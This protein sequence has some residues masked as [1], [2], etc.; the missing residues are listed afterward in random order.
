[1]MTCCTSILTWCNRPSPSPSSMHQPV[2]VSI[3]R[4]ALTEAM[5]L[6]STLARRT[7]SYHCKVPLKLPMRLLDP[8]LAVGFFCKDAH[9]FEDL[10]FR[11]QT[12]DAGSEYPLVSIGHKDPYADDDSRY[13]P[14]V[15]D[16]LL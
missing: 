9:A 14:D 16:F 3:A 10:C 8:S 4:S 15:A 2:Y 11:L 12:V 5:A 6:T 7:Q 1:M 13:I